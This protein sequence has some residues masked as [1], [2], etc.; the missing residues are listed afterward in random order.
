MVQD[1]RT[2]IE[3]P[4]LLRVHRD[5]AALVGRVQR[6]ELHDRSPLL[7]VRH[8]IEP[9]G[10]ANPNV[11]S[12]GT[13]WIS[14]TSAYENDAIATVGG[15]G[16][17]TIVQPGWYTIRGCL[18]MEGSAANMNVVIKRRRNG[19]TG[20]LIGGGAS[21]TAASI[22]MAYP[23]DWIQLCAEGDVVN[24]VTIREHGAGT[25]TPILDSSQES[26][27]LEIVYCSHV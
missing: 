19:A 6:L 22:T 10:G 23:F 18:F 13:E 24:I 20:R 15:D 5:I 1:R 21:T 11:V 9:D 26:S 27:W 14:V 17:W 3:E 12:P 25:F 8:I 4:R 7:R 2:E 16:K